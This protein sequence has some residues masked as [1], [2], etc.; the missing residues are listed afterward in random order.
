MIKL[1]RINLIKFDI[2]EIKSK[3][4]LIKNIIEMNPTDE[5]Q[6][7]EQEDQS[8]Q[9]DKH[10]SDVEGYDAVV[11]ADRKK[12]KL[13]FGPD[14]I[15]VPKPN[16]I[17]I[18]IYGVI[19]SWEFV[20]SLKTY[21]RDNLA[22]YV[23][24]NWRTKLLKLAVAR[25]REQIKVDRLAKIDVPEILED[26]NADQSAVIESAIKSLQWQYEKKH[27]T[28]KVSVLFVCCLQPEPPEG[29]HHFFLFI[30]ILF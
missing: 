29:V 22:A 27:K 9:V 3:Q 6:K 10:P 18:D 5:S 15:K 8:N 26:D 20:N 19:T 25:I 12:R 30:L 23:R 17:L 1:T 2:R 7:S 13:T 4:F 16:N 24:E 28:T 21:A 11:K 14:T